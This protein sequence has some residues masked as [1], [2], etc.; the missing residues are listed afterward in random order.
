MLLLRVLLLLLL[1]F[2]LLV[3][4]LLFRVQA[5]LADPCWLL[6]PD[7]IP[8]IGIILG[9]YGD[10]GKEHRTYCNGLCRV[11]GL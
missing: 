11:Q 8:N 1:L 10:N 2:L 6:A 5:N 7:T 3:L 9:L 4:W